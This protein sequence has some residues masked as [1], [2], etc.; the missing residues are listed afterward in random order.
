MIAGAGWRAR[1]AR[2]ILLTIAVVAACVYAAALLFLIS[3]E[4]RLVFEAG[5][6][7]GALRPAAPFEQVDLPRPDGQRQ[8]AWIM[9]HS[10]PDP[11]A[12]WILYLHGNSANVASRVNIARYEGLRSVGVNVVAP[13]YRGFGG[14]PGQPSEASVTD[15][16]RQAYRF[17]RETLGIPESRIIIFG[18]S[19]GSAVAVNVAAELPSA[20][21]ILEGAPASLVAIGQRRYPW[22]PIRMV[23]RN[24]FESIARVRRISAPML[25]IHSPEDQIIPIEEGRRL[26]AAAPEPKQFVEVR[27]GHIDPADIDAGVYFGSVRAFL[28]ARGAMG[29]TKT[30]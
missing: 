20:A 25:F 24:P 13:E 12:P 16:G 19:L 6:P 4:T 29:A 5:R 15:D 18:W 9:R 17:M 22:M 3:Q 7:L 11:Q 28:R 10:D 1:K 8:F 30:W 2:L 23:M 27:G 26:F 21:V 14:I